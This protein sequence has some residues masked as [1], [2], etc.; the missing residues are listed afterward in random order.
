MSRI[1]LHADIEFL[2]IGDIP[3]LTASAIYPLSDDETGSGLDLYELKHLT[4]LREHEKVLD[5]AIDS[6]MVTPLNSLSH[7]V[8][9][10][11]FGDARRKAIITLDDFKRFAETLQIAVLTGVNEEGLAAVYEQQDKIQREHGRYTLEEA[12]SFIN[13][14]T[15]ESAESM[16]NKLIAAVENGELQ[17]Y[18][19]GSLEK[20]NS[21]ITRDFY[22]HVYWNDLNDW[23][24]KN[25][26]RLDCEFPNP[27][28]NSAPVLQAQTDG[29]VRTNQT[30]WDDAKLWKLW[31]ESILLGVTKTS[32]AKQYGVTRQR[33]SALIAKA[34]GK[35]RV[36]ITSKYSQLTASSR[37]IKGSKY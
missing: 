31:N 12:A 30:N 8:H 15:E 13:E 29:K 11:P 32:L 16:K 6:G 23:L 4:C 2:P 28:D 5:K 25:E 9:T 17:T 35:F 18:A 34:E 27:A 3:E 21:K 19:P 37:T 14:L 20:Y 36:C 26:P 7:A 24:D 1:Y 22:E 33:I 10:F